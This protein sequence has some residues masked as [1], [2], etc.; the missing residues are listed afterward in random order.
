MFAHVR[1]LFLDARFSFCSEPVSV[2]NTKCASV[3]RKMS[4]QMQKISEHVQ[5]MVLDPGF[6]NFLNP[7]MLEMLILQ[8][9]FIFF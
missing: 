7:C 2:G 9:Q 3:V 4:E 6:R 1:K 8:V 5:Q